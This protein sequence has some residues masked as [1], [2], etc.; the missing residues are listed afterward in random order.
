M[1]YC[2]QCGYENQDIAKFCENCGTQLPEEAKTPEQETYSEFAESAGVYEETSKAGEDY[3]ES[4]GSKYE[5]Q[6]SPLSVV[7]FI[8]SFIFTI[9]GLV[10]GIVDLCIGDGRKKGLSIA[11]VVISAIKL[12][13]L[14]FAIIV[15]LIFM[16]E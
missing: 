16:M 12:T 8:C 10:L 3:V 5:G 9:V 4:T 7:A 15:P 2:P 6:N 13:A 1:R 11:A 14:V